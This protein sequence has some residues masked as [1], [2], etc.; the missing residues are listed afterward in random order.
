[1][2]TLNQE[3]SQLTK[4]LHHMMHLLQTQMT[5]HHYSTAMPSYQ[6]GVHMVPNA[7]GGAAAASA[8]L[9]YGVCPS[10]H[11]HQE[12]HVSDLH[13]HHEHAATGTVSVGGSERHAALLHGHGATEGIRHLGAG[14]WTAQGESEVGIQLFWLCV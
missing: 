8:S 4:D 7:V 11:L 10:M 12:H 2:G 13:L 9:A 1:M 5:M 6:Y 3:V 14:T